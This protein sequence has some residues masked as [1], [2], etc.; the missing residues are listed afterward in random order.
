MLLAAWL[1]EGCALEETLAQKEPEAEPR[2]EAVT[3]G[4][5]LPEELAH[6]LPEPG[7]LSVTEA[8]PLTVAQPVEVGSSWLLLIT[9]EALPEREPPRLEGEGVPLA[10]EHW[11]RVPVARFQVR[12]PAALGVM[13]GEMLVWLAANHHMVGVPAAEELREGDTETE[14]L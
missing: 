9:G 7:T 12:L 10:L 13:V 6:M 11:L 14:E 4:L 5:R 1:L 2:V 8:L 3:E